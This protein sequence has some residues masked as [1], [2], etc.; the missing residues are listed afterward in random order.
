M[1]AAGLQDVGRAR[2]FGDTTAGQALP[3]TM[4]RL[5]NHDVLMYAVADFFTKRGTRLD[6]R[7]VIPDEVT[8]VRRAD[9]LA[10]R[11]LALQGALRWLRTDRSRAN[12]P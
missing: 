5:P 9:L 3:A 7:G 11:D 6:R 2:V 4:Y 10:G 1:F 12:T 8:P